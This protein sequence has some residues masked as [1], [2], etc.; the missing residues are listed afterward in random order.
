MRTGLF[1]ATNMKPLF[2][3]AVLLG[4]LVFVLL[5]VAFTHTAFRQAFILFHS[6]KPNVRN[7]R[8]RLKDE[9]PVQEARI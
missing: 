2:D 1:Y 6:L 9:P 7:S 3:I 8:S 5:A 4:L